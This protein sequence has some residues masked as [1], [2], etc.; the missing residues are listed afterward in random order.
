MSEH[1]PQWQ[2][3]ERTIRDCP[4]GRTEIE[5]RASVKKLSKALRSRRG[6]C[7]TCGQSIGGGFSLYVVKETESWLS[8]DGDLPRGRWA[9]S[10][11]ADTLRA[12]NRLKIFMGPRARIWKRISV[13][14]GGSASYEPVK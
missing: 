8:G 12:A 2:I 1:E 3:D 6:R 14:E 13:D 7:R 9:L 10:A 4:G 5:W 11:D